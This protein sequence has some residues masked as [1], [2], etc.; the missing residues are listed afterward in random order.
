MLIRRLCAFVMLFAVLSVAA[1]L[2]QE[3]T[4]HPGQMDPAEKRA[5]DSVEWGPAY[6]ALQAVYGSGNV[7]FKEKV[8]HTGSGK[9]KKTTFEFIPSPAVKNLWYT[10]APAIGK[11]SGHDLA[12]DFLRSHKYPGHGDVNRWYLE[13]VGRPW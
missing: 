11:R 9:N 10:D 13:L 5:F 7:L 3:R 4:V 2:C 1:G 12:N 6:N 8:N